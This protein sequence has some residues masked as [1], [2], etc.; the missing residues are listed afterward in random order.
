VTADVRRKAIAGMLVA[1]L[2]VFGGWIVALSA[3][4]TGEQVK[5]P[6]EGYDPRDL[7]SGHY[8]RF[9]LIAEREARAFVPPSLSES[10]GP[11]EFCAESSADRLHVARYREGG[12]GCR[13]VLRG[14]L[15]H[16]FVEFDVNRFYVDERRAHDVAFVRAGPE[17]Y[18]VATLDGRGGVHVVDL[19]VDGKSLAGRR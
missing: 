13:Y 16:G 18:L 1:D 15:S 10:S 4:T 12:E 7:L 14:Q 19:V 17:T 8:A 11:V 3:A 9:R 2:L 5:L 6:V